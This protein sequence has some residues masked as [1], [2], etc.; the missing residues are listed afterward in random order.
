MYKFIQ[1]LESSNILANIILELTYKCNFNCIYCYQKDLKTSNQFGTDNIL[2]IIDIVKNKGCIFLKLTGGEP[3]TRNDFL[4]IYRY[5]Y[6]KNLKISIST[7]AS[8]IDDKHIDVLKQIPPV[9]IYIS[10]YGSTNKTYNSFTKAKNMFEIVKNNIEKLVVAGFKIQLKTVLN[11][12]NE[13]E[14]MD[15]KNFADY[16]NIDYFVYTKVFDNPSIESSLETKLNITSLVNQNIKG[17]YNSCNAGLTSA[18]INPQ[19][20]IYLCP[21]INKSFDIFKSK[22]FEKLKVLRQ[23]EILVETPCTKC[24]YNKYSSL[25]YPSYYL[26]YKKS[27]NLLKDRCVICKKT[28]ERMKNV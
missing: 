2:K 20:K 18:Y 22:S 19:G 11:K 23:K 25:C 28:L 5:A 3:F 24:K 4:D 8:L 16:Y 21:R 10:V 13:N 9:C 7:N 17:S 14:I 12:Y 1:E 15:I 26:D 27:I 6:N